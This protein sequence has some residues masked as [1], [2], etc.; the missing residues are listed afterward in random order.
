M[1]IWNKILIGFVFLAAAAFSYFAIRTLK[2]HAHWRSLAATYELFH[3]VEKYIEFTQHHGGRELEIGGDP[4]SEA[5]LGELRTFFS[6]RGYNALNVKAGM[7]W[8][9]FMA[10]VS[11]AVARNR[12]HQVAEVEAATVVSACQQCERTLANAARAER[13]RIR[14]Q[15]ITELVLAALDEI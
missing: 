7:D 13:L 6:D 10:E 14:V 12:I 5:K 1:S 9:S 2:T 11:K 4:E 8:Q 15:D 3:E